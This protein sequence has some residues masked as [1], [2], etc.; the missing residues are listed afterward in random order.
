VL[1]ELI[2]IDHVSKALI[3]NSNFIT[4]L[5]KISFKAEPFSWSKLST[6]IGKPKD[7]WKSRTD[8]LRANQLRLRQNNAKIDIFLGKESFEETS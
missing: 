8:K 2:E 5:L 6:A 4:F 1:T 7:G 3:E